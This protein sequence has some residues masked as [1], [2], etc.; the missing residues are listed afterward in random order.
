MAEIASEIGADVFWSSD[1]YCDNRGPVMGPELWC[2]ICL[3]GLKQLIENIK[4]TKKPFIK[5]CDG[6]INSI[7][8]YMIDAGIDCID[9]IDVNAGVNLADIKKRAG[10]R[11]AIKGGV[12]VSLLCNGSIDDVRQSVIG[13]IETAGPGGYILSSSGDI[14][15]SVKP[16]NYAE[17]LKTWHETKKV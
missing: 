7:F 12:P 15:A 1:D 13:C 10:N 5:H 11:I 16:E 3:P 8:D 9:P 6:N 17:M 2:S 4:K 14:T